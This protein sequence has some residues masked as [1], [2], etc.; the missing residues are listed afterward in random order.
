MTG[1]PD[2]P[3]ALALQARQPFSIRA[4]GA[5]KHI[6]RVM[7]IELACIGSMLRKVRTNKK[8]IDAVDGSHLTSRTVLVLIRLDTRV[9]LL[10]DQQ[11]PIIGKPMN[12]Q[13]K[14]TKGHMATRGVS[15]AL[16]QPNFL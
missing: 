7:Q 12:T 9:T 4:D 13:N 5:I 8:I 15:V 2:M 1:L 16:R 14:I 11:K 6:Q 10:R 3:E